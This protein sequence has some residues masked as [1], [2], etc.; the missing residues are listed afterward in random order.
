MSVAD[1]PATSRPV[2]VVAVKHDRQHLDRVLRSASRAFLDRLDELHGLQKEMA[3]LIGRRA[4]RAWSNADYVSYLAL[5]ER[6]R[7]L[8]RE[9][10]RHRSVFD[11]VCA[12]LRNLELA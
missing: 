5:R 4:E 8:Q 12:R 2:S 9:L 7:S 10:A 1:T 6:E 3:D 11:K